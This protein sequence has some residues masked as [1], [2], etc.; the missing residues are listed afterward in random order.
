MINE[1][2]IQYAKSLYDLSQ[3]LEKDLNDLKVLESCIEESTELKKVLMHPSISKE[4]KKEIF[5]NLLENKV[6]NYFLY[7]IYVLVDNDRILEIKDIYD[8]FKKLVD[9]KKQKVTAYVTT[10][11]YLS[12]DIKNELIIYLSKKYQKD[13]V[14]VESISDELIGGIK[15]VVENEVIDYTFDSILKNIKNTIKG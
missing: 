4:E 14:L 7:F 13:I 15:V 10:K 1:V 3:D 9:D 6:N 5:K 12:A 11:N 8:T 2:S